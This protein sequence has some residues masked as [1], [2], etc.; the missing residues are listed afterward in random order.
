MNNRFLYIVAILVLFTCISFAQE[1]DSTVI[2]GVFVFW[3]GTKSEMTYNELASYCAPIFW[4][5][6]D[7]PEL[8]NKSGRDILIPANFPFEPDSSRPVVYYQ[9]RNILKNENET[10]DVVKKDKTDL[11]NSTI[12]LS[13][14][15]GI[16][17]DYSHY[18]QN[19][20]GL[21]GHRHDTEQAQFKVYV[22]KTKLKDGTYYYALILLQVTAKAHALPWYDNIYN[23]DL[24]STELKLPFHILVEEG[25]HAS[26]TDINGDGVYTPGYDVNVRTNDAWGMRDI[27]RTGSLFTAEFQSYMAKTRR[28]EHRVFPPLPDDSPWKAK[29]TMNNIYS[30]DNAVYELR[31]MPNAVLAYPDKLLE[32]DMSG[33]V[34]KQWPVIKKNTDVR[35]FFS[36]FEGDLLIKSFAFNARYDNKAWGVSLTFPLFIVKNVETPLIGGWMV[37]RVYLQNEKFRDFGYNLLITPS[38]SRFMDPYFAA[39]V[40]VVKEVDELGNSKRNTDFVMET[41]LKFRANVIFSPL[42]FLSFLTDFWGVR[43]GIKNKGFPLIKNLGYV[44]EVGAGVW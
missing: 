31:P 16:D 2:S 36:W 13:K 30:P 6:P 18:Y 23:I 14:I 11:N 5:S 34:A 3:E 21:G 32:H 20:A 25:K 19:E 12:D 4:F 43:I 10:G 17:I 15:S 28:P 41:G 26:C 24:K 29:Y 27:I 38:A 33:Y 1:K 40:E 42:K 8:K 7:E 35:K 39:G 37:N 44:F 9:F 22:K